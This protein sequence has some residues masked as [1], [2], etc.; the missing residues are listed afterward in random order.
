MS[1]KGILAGLATATAL[2]LLGV[3]AEASEEQDAVTELLF[4]QVED[5]WPP[6]SELEERIVGESEAEGEGETPEES[7]GLVM[8]QLKRWDKIPFTAGIML[9]DGSA[10]VQFGN[11][12]WMNT[13][14]FFIP[15]RDVHTNIGRYSGQINFA[16]ELYG[17]G[18][19]ETRRSLELKNDSSS[20]YADFNDGIDAT[21]EQVASGCL[22]G[23]ITKLL[24]RFPEIHPHE[25]VY[26][27][28][29]VNAG[30]TRNPES[31]TGR[32]YVDYGLF[33]KAD[34]GEELRLADIDIDRQMGTWQPA[35]YTMRVSEKSLWALLEEP[36]EDKGKIWLQQIKGNSFAN[37]ESVRQAVSKHGAET[38]LPEGVESGIAWDY[39]RV[40]LF[41]YD[42]L[43]CRGETA[44]YTAVIAVPLMEKEDGYYLAGLIRRE[45]ADKTAYQNLLSAIMQTFHEEFYL[46]VVKEG[47]CLSQ[48]AEKYCGGQAAYPQIRLYDE[49]A[50]G[51]MPF[52]DPNLIYPGQKVMLPTVIEYDARRD[53]ATVRP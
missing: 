3:K 49:A 19:E 15:M 42:W 47:E 50:G 35:G 41:Y 46:H 26:T 11:D 2:C 8:E 44:D 13:A 14:H 43:V 24:D 39:N 5:D 16:A 23:E 38:V 33:T 27:L 12:V 22:H 51:A 25:R 32:W 53:A 17:K 36:S 40:E 37:E 30:V 9:Q 4:I 1:G 10:E 18:E 6:E 20:E 28:R 21:R 7:G 48:I 52:A 34:T 29:L 45:A 31:R